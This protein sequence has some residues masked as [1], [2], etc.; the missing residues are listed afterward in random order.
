MH[1]CIYKKQ[2]AQVHD[3]LSSTQANGQLTNSSTRIDRLAHFDSYYFQ[4]PLKLEQVVKFIQPSRLFF[5]HTCWILCHD[6]IIMQSQYAL[7]MSF[8]AHYTVLKF[9]V[10]L[11]IHVSSLF[12]NRSLILSMY[13]FLTAN[14]GKDRATA[15]SVGALRHNRR[16]NLT[17]QINAT[18]MDG[19][20]EVLCLTLSKRYKNISSIMVSHALQENLSFSHQLRSIPKPPCHIT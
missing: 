3:R 13:S 5:F 9:Y 10:Q 14:L 19:L 2:P 18:N 4:R 1:G 11:R 8:L 6:F 17:K 7:K 15:P 20:R 16:I 12:G